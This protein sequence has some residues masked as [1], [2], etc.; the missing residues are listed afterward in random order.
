MGARPR[1]G[2]ARSLSRFLWLDHRQSLRTFK[3]EDLDL[4][5]LE[6]QEK[7]EN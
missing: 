5:T 2:E 3:K 6:I 4:G 1:H 7:H